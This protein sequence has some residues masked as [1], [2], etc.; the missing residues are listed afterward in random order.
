MPHDDS[1]ATRDATGRPRWKGGSVLRQ[2]AKRVG[3]ALGGV[4]LAVGAAYLWT[5][6][7]AL[8]G[9]AAKSTC[10]CLFVS[11]RSEAECLG[12]ELEVQGIRFVDL[13]VDREQ[14]AVTARG[15]GLR[16][17]RASFV[18]GRGCTLE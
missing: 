1:G 4:V 14:S 11:G 8:A 15:F 16:S 5:G 6:A 18:P 9:L 3:V 7:Q 12:P 13:R 17:A 2:V 10:S